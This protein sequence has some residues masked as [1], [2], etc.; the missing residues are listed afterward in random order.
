VRERRREGLTR[1][2]FSWAVSIPLAKM[3]KKKCVGRKEG[4]REGGREGGTH[5]HIVLVGGIDPLGGKVEEA[6]VAWRA[7]HF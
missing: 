2:S 7:L 4:G 1:I 6:G 3:S 5:P